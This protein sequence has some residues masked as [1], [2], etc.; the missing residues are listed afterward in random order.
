MLIKTRG[1]VLKTIKYGETS[2]IAEIYTEQKG[3][4]KY[5]ISGVRSK[6]A[7]VHPSLL[8]V[9]SLVDMVA[10][11]REDR[12][13]NHIKEIKAA[14]V[15]QSVPF[16]VRKGAIALFMA[17][18]IR[19]T[20]RESEENSE[21]FEF[22]FH[23]FQYL[24]ETKLA[25]NNLHLYFLLELS[26]FLGFLPGGECCEA[27]PFFD[28]QE[29]I[30]TNIRPEHRHYLDEELSA[31]L[32]AFLQSN[33]EACHEVSISTAQRRTLLKYLLDYYRLHIDYLPDIHAHEILQE[34]LSS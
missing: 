2:I 29:G 22:L 3:L 31:A 8:Q 13:L 19:K 11:A 17:E 21:L 6:K 30:F 28:L 20:I 10:Y 27:T 15:Y 32:M 14:H 24:D 25:V 9:M 5:I 1:I 18:V 34:V 26:A 16:D 33:P 12:E 4:R 23:I 7:R